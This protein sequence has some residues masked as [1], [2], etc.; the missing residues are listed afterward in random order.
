MLSLLAANGVMRVGLYSE[1][2]RRSIVEARALIAERGYQA[3]A[4]GIR[5][6]RQALIRARE[7]RR[8]ETIITTVDFYSMSGCRDMLFNIMEHRF[9]IPEIAAFLDEQ[10][11]SFLG[12]ELDP[13]TI[14]Q[15]Q[16]QFPGAEAVLDLKHWHSFEQANPLTFRNMYQF[17]IRKNHGARSHNEL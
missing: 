11:L 10:Q 17:S 14:E 16:Q 5:A 3:T 15:F 4:E 1:A 2:A 7:E 8:W 12:F 6:F 9:T 13:R